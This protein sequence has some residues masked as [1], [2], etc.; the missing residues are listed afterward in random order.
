M[1]G[2]Y[3]CRLRTISEPSAEVWRFGWSGGL[4]DGDVVSSNVMFESDHVSQSIDEA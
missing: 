4:V 1:A 3:C 2:G